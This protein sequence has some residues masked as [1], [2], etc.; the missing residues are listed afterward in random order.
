MLDKL[1]FKGIKDMMEYTSNISYQTLL[2]MIPF[3]YTDNSTKKYARKLQRVDD[4]L[5]DDDCKGIHL[6]ERI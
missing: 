5:A 1:C 4:I 3:S 6:Y 2:I